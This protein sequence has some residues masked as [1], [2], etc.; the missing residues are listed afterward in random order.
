MTKIS[1]DK[2]KTNW[3]KFNKIVEIDNKLDSA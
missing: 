1:C 2:V 3:Q